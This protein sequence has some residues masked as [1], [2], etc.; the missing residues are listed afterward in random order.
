[1]PE[2]LTICTATWTAINAALDICLGA[3]RKLQG[4]KNAPNSVR[5][6]SNDLKGTYTVLG[7][8][9]TILKS[10]SNSL[11]ECAPA[12]A[13]ILDMEPLIENCIGVFTEISTVTNRF[14]MANG[15][16]KTGFGAR[17]NWDNFKKD[18]INSLRASLDSCKMTLQVSCSALTL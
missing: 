10:E 14:L 17:F 7:A 13:L 12:A 11:Q 1:M 5:R 4:L 16:A 15:T 6:L 9:Q 3:H 18:D 8:L 2:P